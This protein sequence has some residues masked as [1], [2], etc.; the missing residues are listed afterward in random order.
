M[1]VCVAVKVHDCIVFSA[2][3]AST[4][5]TKDSEGNNQVLNVYNNAD[6]VFNL[7]RGLPIVAMTCGMGHIGGRSIS[8]LAKEFR[9]QISNGDAGINKTDYTIEEVARLAHKFFSECYNG[10]NEAPA[11]GDYME[12]WIGGYGS[13]NTHGEIWR[14]VIA[15][16]V[17]LEPEN[18]VSEDARQGVFWGGQ[19]QA[20]SRLLLGLDP[21]FV[22]AMTEAGIKPELAQELYGVARNKLEA[23]LL[24][25][26]MP[27]IDAIRMAEFLV[28]TT[29][30]YFALAFGSDIVGGATDTAT[31]TKWEGFKW[32]NRKHFYPEHLNRKDHDH[33][34]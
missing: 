23:K 34:C 31:V 30:G 4:L 8:N 10:A 20:I 28:D 19:G 21:A 32:I 24:D 3:S 22:G 29:K 16:G 6:K 1:T 13:S 17:S 33:V 5:S 7:H 2:D 27:T 12:F 11:K 26:T 14:N 25:A 18:L 9:H 15:D